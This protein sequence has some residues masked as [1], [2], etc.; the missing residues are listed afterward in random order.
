MM[1]SFLPPMVKDIFQ[2]ALEPSYDSEKGTVE[3][4]DLG[5]IVCLIH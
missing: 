4:L 3:L 5:R 2:L 1:V